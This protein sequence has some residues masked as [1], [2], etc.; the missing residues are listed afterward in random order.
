MNILLEGIVG[1]TAY[2]LAHKDSDIDKK[3]IFAFATND[4]FG[5]NYRTLKEVKETHAPEPD[6]TWY[7]VAKWCSLAMKCNPNI[8]EVV[9]LPD[10]LYTV[11]TDLGN[12][13]IEIRQAFLSAPA[14]RGAYIN[15]ARS[16]L[17]QIE[18]HGHFGS[19]MKKRTEKHAR[20]L[21]RLMIQ[22]YELY[23]TGNL[24][25]RL[26]DLTAE[27]VKR[28]GFLAG[29]GD[30][31]PLKQVYESYKYA[32]E[33]V[34]PVLPEEPNREAIESWLKHVRKRFLKV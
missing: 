12:S 1:S 27:Q 15:Y 14:V 21:M 10:N 25:V 29:Q 5:L 22:G 7:E 3:G 20:H 24:T 30:I 16:Q 33:Q 34:D 26:G 9:F 4:L 31:Q 23:T 28:I 17:H 13:L 11:R 2:N 18:N 8:L 6:N 32:F 19:D